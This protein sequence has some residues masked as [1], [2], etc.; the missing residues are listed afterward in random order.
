MA[1][2]EEE[3]KRAKEEWDVEERSS[4]ERLRKNSTFSC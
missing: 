2:T 4:P 3:G 1:M